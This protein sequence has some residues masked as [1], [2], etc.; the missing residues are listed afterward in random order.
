MPNN[1]YEN[2]IKEMESIDITMAILLC[3][4]FDRKTYKCNKK[5]NIT[6]LPPYDIFY[7]IENT[8]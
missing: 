5:T 8:Y 6:N 1:I 7:K 2:I 4:C 3:G